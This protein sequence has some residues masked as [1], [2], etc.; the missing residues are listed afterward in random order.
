MS[1]AVWA[2]CIWVLAASATALLPMR[3]Q[4]APGLT[5]L[6]AA[7]LL[8]LWLGAVEGWG[9]AAL[10]LAGFASMFRNPL[11]YLFRR[12]RGEQPEIPR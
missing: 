3:H 8:L 10:G 5:L 2:I 7:P 9:W 11:V 4:Y 1:A 6:L 12:A